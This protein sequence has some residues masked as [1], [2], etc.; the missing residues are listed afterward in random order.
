MS[1]VNKTFFLW[2]SCFHT[3]ALL[4]VNCTA[5]V[6]FCVF[7]FWWLVKSHLRGCFGCF[8][9]KI[10]GVPA[11]V[12]LHPL[13]KIWRQDPSLWIVFTLYSQFTKHHVIEGN[14]THQSYSVFVHSEMFVRKLVN[15]YIRNDFIRDW[16]LD[17]FVLGLRDK[18]YRVYKRE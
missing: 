2:N 10:L 4:W 1:L 12:P 13:C 6:L 15:S 11:C 17:H 18:I 8:C 9:P 5:Y 7:S 14:T 3:Y 16:T